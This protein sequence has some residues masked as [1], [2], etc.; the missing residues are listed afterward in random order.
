MIRSKLRKDYNVPEQF[1]NNYPKTIQAHMARLRSEGL[2]RPLPFG[3]DFTDEELVLGRALKALKKKAVSKRKILQ[4]L[5]RAAASSNEVL[6]PYL[7]R[8]GLETPKTLEEKLYARL[9]RAELGSLL[10][11]PPPTHP[12]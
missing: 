2:F 12:S 4:L 5:L 8:M 1:R 9:L 3:T 10:S 11:S 7:R 6:A